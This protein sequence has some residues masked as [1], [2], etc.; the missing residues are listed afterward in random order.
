M[1]EIT[2]R[3]LRAKLGDPL[4][5]KHL[6]GT[7]GVRADNFKCG[8]LRIVRLRVDEMDVEFHPCQVHQQEFEGVTV[9]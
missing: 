4:T 1:A 6:A 7:T 5:E 2:Y 8:C 9:L 3:E